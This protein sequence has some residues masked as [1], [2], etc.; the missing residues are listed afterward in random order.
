MADISQFSIVTY[1]RRPGHWC[2]AITPYA[3]S[4]L[5]IRGKTTARDP[6][7]SLTRSLTNAGF[8]ESMRR[9]NEGGGLTVS[10]CHETMSLQIGLAGR[11]CFLTPFKTNARHV[12][13]V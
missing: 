3:H 6:P 2:A 7:P 8:E 11:D 13:N 9:V 1:E 5:F 10:P 4:R 12:R